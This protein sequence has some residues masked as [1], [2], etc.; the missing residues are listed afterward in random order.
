MAR[1]TL[2]SLGI[3]IKPAVI[4]AGWHAVAANMHK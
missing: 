4:E 2:F 3:R 1:F